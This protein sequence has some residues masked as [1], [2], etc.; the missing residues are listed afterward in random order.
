MLALVVTLSLNSCDMVR[1]RLG[2]PT[3]VEIK[4]KQIRIKDSQKASLVKEY[5]APFT[6]TTEQ[7]EAKRFHIIVGCYQI[8]NNAANMM[9]QLTLSGFK[10]MRIPFPN[11][12]LAVSAASYDDHS[13]AY[14]SMRN[15]LERYSY[16]PYD[17]WIYDVKQNLHGRSNVNYSRVIRDE[18]GRPQDDYNRMTD[19]Y[20]IMN[21]VYRRM[22][23]EYGKKNENDVPV[24]NENNPVYPLPY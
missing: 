20:R 6:E 5:P 15:M 13:E 22:N 2:M 17:M 11:G 16:L 21:E 12:F 24:Q 19:D 3:S 14:R 9:T 8:E 10:P 7:P 18:M 1:S 4:E 23:E